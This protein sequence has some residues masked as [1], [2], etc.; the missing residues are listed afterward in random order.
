M[1][2]IGRTDSLRIVRFIVPPLNRLLAKLATG[3]AA[4]SLCLQPATAQSVLR[5]AET[6]ALFAAL[7]EAAELLPASRD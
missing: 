5:D 1:Q 7:L 3:F 4:L 2:F 6:E